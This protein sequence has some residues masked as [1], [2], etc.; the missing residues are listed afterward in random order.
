MRRELARI[1]SE[2]EAHPSRYTIRPSADVRAVRVA[3]E[4]G[5]SAEI[6]RAHV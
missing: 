5:V 4:E 3:V 6:G 2:Y 1:E